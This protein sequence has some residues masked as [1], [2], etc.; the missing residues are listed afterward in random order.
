MEGPSG[1]LETYNFELSISSHGMNSTEHFENFCGNSLALFEI[2]FVYSII[3][4]ITIRPTM[5]DSILLCI[6]YRDI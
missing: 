5:S 4:S 6:G 2:G 1:Q 3:F